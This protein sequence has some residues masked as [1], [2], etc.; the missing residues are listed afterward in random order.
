[1]RD[2]RGLFEGFTASFVWR[3]LGKQRKTPFR[4]SFLYLY[5]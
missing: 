4:I 1:M 3:Y 2:G 5:L